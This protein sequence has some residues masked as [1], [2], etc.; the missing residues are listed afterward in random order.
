VT[1]AECPQEQAVVNAVLS[2]SW[3]DRA[4]SDLVAHAVTCDTCRE[5]AAVSV[6]LRED[7]E[8]SRIEMHIPAA[9]QI[10]W[11][12]AVRARLEST[13]AATRPMTW[14]HGITGAVVL[15]ALLAAL[16]AV[17]PML[18]GLART[19]RSVAVEYLPSPEVAGALASGLRLSV[20]AGVMIAAVLIVAPLALYF[21]LS[22]D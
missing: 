9:G 10:W 11:R 21:V 20:M 14:M 4:D 5:I 8:H 12:A 22:D 7:A 17:W 6:L 13:H 1:R 2:G 15:G 19:A 3:P 18:P 16:T